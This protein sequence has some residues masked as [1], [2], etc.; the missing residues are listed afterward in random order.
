MQQRENG[1][2]SQVVMRATSAMNTGIDDSSA[3]NALQNANLSWSVLQDE[4]KESVMER[5]QNI[6]NLSKAQSLNVYN[7]MKGYETNTLH[8]DLTQCLCWL[9]R[10]LQQFVLRCML[11]CAFQSLYICHWSFEYFM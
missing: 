9:H 6:L 1:S 10:S 7:S 4:H 8:R 11:P 2:F 5:F 3:R